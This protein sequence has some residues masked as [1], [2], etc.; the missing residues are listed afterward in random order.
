MKWPAV[1]SLFSLILGS[2]IWIAV[3][4]SVSLLDPAP[5][6]GYR[7]GVADTHLYLLFSIAL[8]T[9]G[10]VTVYLHQAHDLPFVGKAAFLLAL[11]GFLLFGGGRLLQEF[12]HN[13]Q[14]MAGIGWILFAVF[15][16]I[17]SIVCLVKGVF[18]PTTRTVLLLAAI[19]LLLLSDLDWRSWLAVP[20]G[21]IWAWIG[22]D[23]LHKEIAWK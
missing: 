16:V 18:Y 17:Y 12:G 1:L 4:T 8:M 22:I 6:G 10:L 9:A 3:W 15:L 21:L 2:L 11:A 19:S 7:E 20:F 13:P 14:P 23:K 5:P